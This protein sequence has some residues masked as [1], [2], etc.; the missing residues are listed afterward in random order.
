MISIADLRY[1]IVDIPHLS[2]PEGISAVTG[3]NGAGKTTL[4][5]LAAGM[6]LPETGTITINGTAPRAREVGCVSEFPDR[7]LIFSVVRDEIAS[8][9]RFA[10][11][12]PAEIDD[13]VTA[14]TD[15]LGIAHLLDRECRT[16]SGGEKMLVGI[17][18]A[19]IAKPVLITL[20]EPDSHLDPQTTDELF[21]IIRNSGC[22]YVLWSTHS[23]SVQ[24][25]ADR[26]ITLVYRK[27]SDL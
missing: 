10:H 19:L 13:A 6:L 15:R 8:P 1:G 9:L 4:L 20:D 18:T 26:R 25:R 24:E 17:A 14:I 22:P 11:R 27:V 2:I 23:R 3:D 7:H 5:R 16:L 12:K 21:Q